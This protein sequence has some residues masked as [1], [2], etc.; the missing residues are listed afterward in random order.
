MSSTVDRRVRPGDVEDAKRDIAG[1]AGHVE[2]CERRVLRGLQRRDQRVLP[3]R[4]RPADM[5]S[6]IRS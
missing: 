5:R 6:F 1:A 3:G 4:C 2:E